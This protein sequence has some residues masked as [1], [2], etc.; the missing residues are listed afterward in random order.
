MELL[1][2]KLC[3][4]TVL[5]CYYLD[6]RL[7]LSNRNCLELLLSAEVA[8]RPL[9]KFL[10]I[11]GVLGLRFKRGWSYWKAKTRGYKSPEEGEPSSTFKIVKIAH[12]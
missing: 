5:S 6:I 1:L 3:T 4:V 8:F 10:T 2:S 12:Q 7:L 9:L 11:S